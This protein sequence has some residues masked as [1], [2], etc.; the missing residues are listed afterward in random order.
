VELNYQKEH[1]KKEEKNIKE[2][3]DVLNLFRQNIEFADGEFTSKLNSNLQLNFVGCLD[4]VDKQYIVEAKR[5]FSATDLKN[6]INEFLAKIE[7]EYDFNAIDPIDATRDQQELSEK[8]KQLE[9]FRE[10]MGPM[11]YQENLL[12]ADDKAKLT[13]IDNQTDLN[14]IKDL[15]NKI[16]KLL[17]K[18]E[19]FVLE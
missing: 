6:S 16:M 18:G 7:K 17:N 2:L 19:S 13:D 14:V 1:N 3:R 9:K 5:D 11:L 12:T 8:L 4:E 15:E 10:E